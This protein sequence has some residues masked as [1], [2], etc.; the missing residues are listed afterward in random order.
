MESPVWV[1]FAGLDVVGVCE[2][3]EEASALTSFLYAFGD[4]TKDYHYVS[5]KFITI[6]HH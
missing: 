5:T 4:N 2:T 6:S 1:V 3:D